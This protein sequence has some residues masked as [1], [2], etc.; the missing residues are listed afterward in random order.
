MV[1]ERSGLARDVIKTHTVDYWET[2]KAGYVDG[3][4]TSL[5]ARR[6]TRTERYVHIPMPW[7]K[8]MYTP[9]NDDFGIRRPAFAIYWHRPGYKTLS[10]R[11]G[12]TS[13]AVP[14]QL[15]ECQGGSTRSPAPR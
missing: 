7:T 10:V 14:G 8:A 6:A 1:S 13:W 2:D 9:A 5:T 4:W 11:F 12:W 3:V 15:G